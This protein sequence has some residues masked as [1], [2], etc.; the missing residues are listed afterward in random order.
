[1]MPTAIASQV[2]QLSRSFREEA[3]DASPAKYQTS[4][5]HK[6][7]S[8]EYTRSLPVTRNGQGMDESTSPLRKVLHGV[9]TIM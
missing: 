3:R 6:Q 1:M 8:L 7:T 2:D 9:F 5:A 4:Q